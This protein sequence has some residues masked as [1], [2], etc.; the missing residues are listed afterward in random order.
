MYVGKLAI[1]YER[2]EQLLGLDK[3]AHVVHIS[4]HP[5]S[6]Y[7]TVLISDPKLEVD[8]REEEGYIPELG[9]NWFESRDGWHPIY[10][11]L[12]NERR[13]HTARTG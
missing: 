1:D 3:R 13:T 7:C 12:S 4:C 5:F 2:L 8:E 10:W 9:S 6:D 11:P